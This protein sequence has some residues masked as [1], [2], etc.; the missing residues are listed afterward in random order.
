MLYIL[1]LAKL[2]N[3]KSF[4]RKQDDSKEENGRLKR[5]SLD[6]IALDCVQLKLRLWPLN[7][8]L[9]LVNCLP[10]KAQMGHKTTFFKAV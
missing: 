1:L 10:H 7:P 2:T 4:L 6:E 8:F 5:M 3:N 9:F